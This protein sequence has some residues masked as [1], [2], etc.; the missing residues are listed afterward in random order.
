[1][2]LSRLG[3]ILAVIIFLLAVSVPSAVPAGENVILLTGFEPFGGD[4][5]NSSWEAIK[6]LDGQTFRSHTIKSRL[7]PVT[8]QGST[9]EL[10]RLINRFSPRVVI[11]FGLS[12]RRFVSIETIARNQDKTTFPDNDGVVRNGVAIVPGGP[13]EKPPRLPVRDIYQA[14]KESGIPVDMS[15]NAGGYVCNHVFYTLMSRPL[16]DSV[17]RGFIHLPSLNDSTFSPQNLERAVMTILRVVM[18]SGG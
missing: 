3:P 7:L 6:N 12:G 11:C 15:S 5:V 4:K 16:D 14:L 8:Y 2:I 17:P 18:N 13:A 9:E 10:K 1:M